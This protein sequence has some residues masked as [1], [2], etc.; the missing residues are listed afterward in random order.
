MY[1]IICVSSFKI[2][3]FFI[4]FIEEMNVIKKIQVMMLKLVDIQCKTTFN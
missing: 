2:L 3:V 4:S 1:V